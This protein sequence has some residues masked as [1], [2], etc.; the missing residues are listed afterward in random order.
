MRWHQAH[1]TCSAILLWI[2]LDVCPVC[3]YQF[4]GLHDQFN[5][6]KPNVV[7]DSSSNH[8]VVA[9]CVYTV[10]HWQIRE[11]TRLVCEDVAD[12]TFGITVWGNPHAE[13]VGSLFLNSVLTIFRLFC[14][15]NPTNMSPHWF[16]SPK[17]YWPVHFSMHCLVPTL[18]LKSPMTML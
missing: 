3:Q 8:S 9:G 1:W 10:E 4:P 2:W 18:A 12:L 14:S 15:A 16:L 6:L 11:N 13:S 7:L 5:S 17:P